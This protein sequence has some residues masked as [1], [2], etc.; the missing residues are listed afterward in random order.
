MPDNLKTHGVPPFYNAT[1]F[2]AMTGYARTHILHACKN[3]LEGFTA[4]SRAR[5]PI[6]W[7]AFR[8]ER[9]YIIC[10]AEDLSKVKEIFGI[11]D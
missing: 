3:H 10:L 6:G 9:V 11:L 8:W 2:A 5:M 4:K 7:S 1:E